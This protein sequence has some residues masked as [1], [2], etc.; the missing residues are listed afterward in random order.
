LWGK[1]P[2]RKRVGGKFPEGNCPFINN[3]QIAFFNFC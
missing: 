1:C 2:T 3:K